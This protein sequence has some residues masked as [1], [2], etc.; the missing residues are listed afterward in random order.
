MRADRLVAALLLMQTRGRITAAEIA[1]ELEVSVATARRD[2]EALSASGIPVYPQTGRGGGWQLVGGA[3][4]DLTG[5][6]SIEAQALFTLVGPA[7]ALTPDAKAALRKLVRALPAPFRDDAQA[8]AEASTIDPARWGHTPANRP[9]EVRRLQRAIVG[10]LEATFGYAGKGARTVG[11]LGLVEKNDKW[12]LIAATEHGQRTY[13]VDRMTDVA[14][15]QRSFSRPADFDLADAW[16]SVVEAVEA[17]QRT[18]TATVVIPERLLSVLENQFG[19]QCVVESITDG[20]LRARVSAPA[21]VMIAQH[22]AGWGRALEVV[23][24]DSVR[25]EL[26]RIG[27]ELVE[28]YGHMRA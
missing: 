25:A 22:L 24:S 9:D 12:Y 1:E 7:A 27:A 28:S 10:R 13:R 15:T 6:T 23:E 17:G 4:T 20:R 14:V 8:A 3:R 19:R 26:A 18:T 5:L 11:P 2:L 21:P 16:A